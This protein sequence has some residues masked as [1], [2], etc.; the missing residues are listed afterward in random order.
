MA[1]VYRGIHETLQR[2]VAIKEL[3]AESMR[4]REA[5]SRFRREALA[6]A[7]FRHQNIVTLYDLVEKNDTLYMIMEFVD[8]PTLSDLLKEEPI[9]PIIAA[10]IGARLASALDHAHFNRIIH[11]DIKPSNVMIT[12]AGAE[13]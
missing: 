7:A 4:D 3:T 2:E 12:K 10:L 5:Q 13:Q 9:P 8:G 6:L 1:I 11:R